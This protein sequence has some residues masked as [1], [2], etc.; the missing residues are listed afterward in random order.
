MNCGLPYEGCNMKASDW[1][2]P[3]ACPSCEAVAG[4][5]YRVQTETPTLTLALRCGNCRHEWDISA[6]SPMLF[7]KAKH[8]RRKSP[9]QNRQS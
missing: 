4:T 8:D 3:M 6:P 1:R 7:V 2:F 9:Q 5:P